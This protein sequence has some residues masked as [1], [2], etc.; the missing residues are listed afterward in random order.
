M[1][2]HIDTPNN[3]NDQRGSSPSPTLIVQEKIDELFNRRRSRVADDKAA[4]TGACTMKRRFQSWPRLIMSCLAIPDFL[5]CLKVHVGSGM[6]SV[7]SLH[8]C[9]PFFA[10]AAAPQCPAFPPGTR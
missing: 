1:R 6:M 7:V 10:A 3:V 8:P 4:V 9:R 5:D 2:S